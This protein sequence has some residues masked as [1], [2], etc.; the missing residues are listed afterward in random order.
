[1]VSEDE[2]RRHNILD[3]VID[4]KLIIKRSTTPSTLASGRFNFQEMTWIP[5]INV[6]TATI[7]IFFEP[8]DLQHGAGA[9]EDELQQ[10]R[11]QGQEA[12]ER[13]EVVI[14]AG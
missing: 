1:M 12:G 10:P 13:F 6:R 2:V 9:A 14:T 11:H 3:F 7:P 4:V 5:D 8:R